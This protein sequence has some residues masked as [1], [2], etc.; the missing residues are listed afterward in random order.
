MTDNDEATDDD[1]V[2]GEAPCLVGAGS[3]S[4]RASARARHHGAQLPRRGAAVKGTPSLDPVLDQLV[5]QRLRLV[6]T[7]L[8]TTFVID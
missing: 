6:G 1:V 4:E 3:K 2:E 5:G 7:E 8:D